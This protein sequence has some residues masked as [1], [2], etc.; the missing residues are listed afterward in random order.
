MAMEGWRERGERHD[1]E[2]R[3]IGAIGDE[4]KKNKN[5]KGRGCEKCNKNDSAMKKFHMKK[6]ERIKKTMGTIN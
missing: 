4:E 1:K 6:R 3:E 2:K 5:R